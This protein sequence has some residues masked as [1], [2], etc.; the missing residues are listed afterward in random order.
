[1]SSSG[2]EVISQS[3]EK[4]KKQPSRLLDLCLSPLGKNKLLFS[5]IKALPLFVSTAA[6]W[7]DKGNVIAILDDFIIGSKLFIDCRHDGFHLR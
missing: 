7:R 2:L 1:M 4:V 3:V 5:L 6:Y